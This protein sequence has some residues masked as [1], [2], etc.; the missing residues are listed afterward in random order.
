[1]GRKSSLFLKRFLVYGPSVTLR[2]C[3]PENIGSIRLPLSR[4]KVRGTPPDPRTDGRGRQAG[5][6][7]GMEGRDGRDR[8]MGRNYF[9][10]C[11]LAQAPSIDRI[12]SSRTNRHE[13]IE[14]SALPYTTHI[15]PCICSTHTLHQHAHH[16]EHC[17]RTV[18]H[19]LHK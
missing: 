14:S 18:I 13:S 8:R 3:D 17:H 7:D 1:M 10:W 9:Y 5:R 4:L 12:D 6:T 16:G 11:L 19:M 15:A 2:T